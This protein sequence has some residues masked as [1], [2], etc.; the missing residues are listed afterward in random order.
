MSCAMEVVEAVEAVEGLIEEED[1][2][3]QYMQP[4]K[5]SDVPRVCVD[6]QRAFLL[7]WR[8]KKIFSNEI[9]TSIYIYW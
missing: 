4:L 7:E 6:Y 8:Q 9:L 1:R 5:I 3:I 2:C